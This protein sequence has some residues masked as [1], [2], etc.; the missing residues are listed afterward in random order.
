M[1]T[2][3]RTSLTTSSRS[4]SR[5]STVTGPRGAAAAWILRVSR[6]AALDHLRARRQIP[7]EEVRTTDEGQAQVGFG[8]SQS[9]RR[10]FIACL[11]DQ[12]EVLVLRL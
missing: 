9:L 7:F 11:Q 1:S 5:R 4:W 2:R 8:R 12:R 6:N 10:P 3:P